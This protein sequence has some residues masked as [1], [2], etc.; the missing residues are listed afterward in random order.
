MIDQSIALRV[1]NPATQGQTGQST[2]FN[3]ATALLTAQ[4]LRAAL[5][6]Q[7]GGSQLG[8]AA[9]VARAFVPR[10][11]EFAFQRPLTDEDSDPTHCTRLA[12][13]RPKRAAV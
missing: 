10:D 9:R 4:R 13:E 11:N 5:Q 3:P 7:E 2:A 6:P 1:N 8:Q 12:I